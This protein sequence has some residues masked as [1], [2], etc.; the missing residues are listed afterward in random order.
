M[1]TACR[2][3]GD[4]RAPAARTRQLATRLAPGLGTPR[5]PP[6]RAAPDATASCP[7]GKSRQPGF[8]RSSPRLYCCRPSAR[9]ADVACRLGPAEFAPQGFKAFE[10]E[11]DGAFER[12]LNEA[13]GAD[14][15]T[16]EALL[17]EE[18]AEALKWLTP[19]PSGGKKRKNFL[20]RWVA[21]MSNGSDDACLELLAEAAEL[22]L[23][24]DRLPWASAARRRLRETLESLL[25]GADEAA[26]S[27]AGRWLDAFERGGLPTNHWEMQHL[28][29]RWRA[30]LAERSAS[31]A[32]RRLAAAF[33]EKLG[34]A[35]SVL[36]LE[37]TE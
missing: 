26:L 10:R 14:F 8:R 29:W 19:D 23:P 7:R 3:L 9:Q 30:R 28:F 4:P 22:E 37:A 27:R 35:D 15:L 20:D 36:P 32:E 21:E 13:L 33:G 17:A 34:F 24:A 25:D 31:S 18:R 6:N 2:P 1:R 5:A 11:D 16:L 12:C